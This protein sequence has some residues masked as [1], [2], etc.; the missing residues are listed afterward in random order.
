[1]LAGCELHL[2]VLFTPG[3]ADDVPAV[4]GCRRGVDDENRSRTAPRRF[5][6]FI[7]PTSVIRERLA[8]EK[9]RIVGRRLVR[10]KN[11]DFPVHIHA[12]VVVPVK[13]GRDD[14]V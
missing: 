7:C 3:T 12:F 4:T 14:A 6:V 2:R 1:M 13:L 10:E 8:S 9:T 11:D 5:L